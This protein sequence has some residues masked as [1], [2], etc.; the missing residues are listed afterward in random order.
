MTDWLLDGVLGLLLLGGRVADLVGR[1][2][3]PGPVAEEHRRGAHAVQAEVAG[4]G[5]RPARVPQSRP[6]AGGSA[7]AGM[8]TATPPREMSTSSPAVPFTVIG[9]RTPTR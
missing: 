5:H 8:E 9:A 7:P 2:A 6:D 4:L 1:L 3:L